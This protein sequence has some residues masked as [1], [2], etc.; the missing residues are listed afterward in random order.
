[1]FSKF[2]ITKWMM[3]IFRCLTVLAVLTGLALLSW[4]VTIEYFL[5]KTISVVTIRD[6][7]E[8][9]TA[10][11]IVICARFK[12]DPRKAYKTEQ[13]FT[14]QENFLKDWNDT[15]KVA[16]VYSQVITDKP[17]DFVSM[18]YLIGNKYCLFLQVKNLFKTEEVTSRRIG[19]LPNFFKADLT[20]QPFISKNI[21]LTP[22]GRTDKRCR[23]IPQYIQILSDE[24]TRSSTK[25]PFSSHNIC[26]KTSPELSLHF[27][28]TQ[29]V[30]I[31]LPPPFETNCLDYRSVG[32]FLS[33]D[34]CL[35]ECLKR[36]TF[37]YNIVPGDTVIDRSRYLHSK[38][39]I[40]PPDIIEDSE[41][42]KML[43][44]NS[45]IPK[46]LLTSFRNIHATWKDMKQLCRR[47]CIRPD[48]VSERITP[49]KAMVFSSQG[50]KNATLSVIHF[51]L[52]MSEQPLLYVTS[53]PKQHLLDYIVYMC[54]GLSF[55]LGF[56][57]LTIAGQMQVKVVTYLRRRE[58]RKRSKDS[59]ALRKHPT[60]G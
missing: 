2:S 1:M 33:S 53:A 55:W 34:D 23:Q 6:Y 24:S 5:Y 12:F 11:A 43:A 51:T 54:S 22:N 9:V 49:Q 52:K 18:K 14:G 50:K 40:A 41:M 25:N 19:S 27:T 32:E 30:S 21:F 47:K 10:P 29:S 59:W 44:M 58:S 17:L 13:L 48:C 3:R 35:D 39:D 37:E 42:I 46:T 8:E 31:R 4:R 38:M 45:S 36:Q 20:A 15:W 57:P 7:P 60:S 56:C 26:T 28:Y 16:T